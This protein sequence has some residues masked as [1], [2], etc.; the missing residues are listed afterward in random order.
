MLFLGASLP[1]NLVNACEL[2]PGVA[3]APF[4]SPSILASMSFS[5]LQKHTCTCACG[6]VVQC[7]CSLTQ[8]VCV[9]V[10]ARSGACMG[11]EERAGVQV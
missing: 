6:H 3:L 8:C 7:V 2:W 5:V 10:R 9:C 4:A 11:E 1:N